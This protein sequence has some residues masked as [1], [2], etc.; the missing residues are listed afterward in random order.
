MSVLFIV[1]LGAVNYVGVRAGANLQNVL[2]IIKTA[3]LVVISGAI[4]IFG[5]G[6]APNFVNP[7]RGSFNMS[8]LGSFGGSLLV[9][10]LYIITNLAY[11]YMFPVGAI[12]KSDRIASDAVSLAV[13]PAGERS[14]LSSSSSLSPGPT[15]NSGRPLSRSSRCVSGAS[16]SASSGRLAPHSSQAIIVTGEG[17]R[18]PAA[19]NA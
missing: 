1:S 3:A 5:K 14:S 17:D 19:L 15:R 10:A 6:N 11:L 12:A 13:G 16:S 7:A 8:L 9:L 18:T 4:F 2:T